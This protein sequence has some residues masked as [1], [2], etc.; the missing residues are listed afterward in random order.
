[1]Y[2]VLTRTAVWLLLFAFNIGGSAF[3]DDAKN[4]PLER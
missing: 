2:R 3:A 4:V 1:V